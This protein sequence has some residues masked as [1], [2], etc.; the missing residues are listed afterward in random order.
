MAGITIFP[1]VGIFILLPNGL[2]SDLLTLPKTVGNIFHCLYLTS[3]L[4]CS[5]IYG[6]FEAMS[7]E[8]NDEFMRPLLLQERIDGL[9]VRIQELVRN[10]AKKTLLSEENSNKLKVQ[11]ETS[12][13]SSEAVDMDIA[14][15]DD[16]EEKRGWRVE[17][18][19]TKYGMENSLKEHPISTSD[20]KLKPNLPH[21]IDE[22]VSKDK[23]L[24]SSNPRRGKM[25]IS[26]D[27][28]KRLINGR[29]LPIPSCSVA[30]RKISDWNSLREQSPTPSFGLPAI[31]FRG[32][33][34]SD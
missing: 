20:S 10:V 17:R 30:G 9:D 26:R 34:P 29:D 8:E 32:Y 22:A 21:S 25:F 14:D 5:L 13:A 12:N 33:S 16:D 2:F 15:S 31:D 23:R 24:L 27:P 19:N 18:M 3:D 6:A 7:T 11:G 4:N 1:S 28:R